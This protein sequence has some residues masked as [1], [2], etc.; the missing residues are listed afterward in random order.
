MEW[1]CNDLFFSA[2]VLVCS[3]TSTISWAGQLGEI[4]ERAE[5]TRCDE[6]C[7]VWCMSA[8]IN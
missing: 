1:I 4:G 6:A 7:W 8:I 5:G 3:W 2:Y